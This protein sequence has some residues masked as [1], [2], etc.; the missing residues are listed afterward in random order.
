MHVYPLVTAPL[1]STQ[2]RQNAMGGHL[3]ALQG[4]SFGGGGSGGA[5]SVGPHGNP[6]PAPDKK[7]KVKPMSKR[8]STS[9]G[10]CSTKVNEI[11]VWK[12]KLQENKPGLKLDSQ[13]G[14]HPT[15]CYMVKLV[16]Y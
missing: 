14:P 10:Q 1:L 12:A 16:S 6:P 3:K 2:P 7:D 15:C 13:V 4:V 11:L 8:L 5:G 9:I